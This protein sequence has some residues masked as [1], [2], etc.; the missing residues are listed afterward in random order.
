MPGHWYYLYT[1][2][3]DVN[4]VQFDDDGVPVSTAAEGVEP[5][6]EVV[7]C[8]IISSVVTVL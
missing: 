7:T 5:Y 6:L 3:L 1:H 4:S 8:I 2:T